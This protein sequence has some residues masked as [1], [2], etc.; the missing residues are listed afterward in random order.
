MAALLQWI[1]NRSYSA[2]L[3][4][5]R[6][7]SNAKVFRQDRSIE[8]ET[9]PEYDAEEFYPVHIGDVFHE[10]YQVLGKL[11]YGANSTVWL[12]RDTEYASLYLC[13]R[14]PHTASRLTFSLI[15]K[16]KYVAL[17]LYVRTRTGTMIRE[18]LAYE[19]LRSLRSSHVGQG[20]VRELLD[21]FEVERPDG[22]R[23]RCL[24]HSPLH[25]AL[26]DLQRLGGESTAF[27]EDMVRG[28]LPYLCQALDFLHTEA[29]ITHCGI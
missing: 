4:R 26:S 6:L 13:D 12:C 28:A 7:T 9:L 19:R 21:S 14:F 11:G 20:F 17:K 3:P 1:R 24:V 25:V 5:R 23:H 22:S 15:R 2:S 10:K 29:N 18:I 27:P 8:E 16:H